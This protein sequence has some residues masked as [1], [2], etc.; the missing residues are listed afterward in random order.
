MNTSNFFPIQ[1]SN[2]F[3][4]VFDVESIGLHGEGFAVSWLVL[5]LH[6][7]VVL[8]EKTFSCDPALATGIAPDREWVAA[9]VPALE[10]NCASPTE[11]RACFWRAWLAWRE[12]SAWLAADAAWPVETNFLSAC[13]RD[14]GVD[15][16][17][18]GPYP[19]IDIDAMITASGLLTK[20]ELTRHAHELPVH[21][22]TA[23]TRFSARRL[24]TMLSKIKK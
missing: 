3:C 21:N 10:I 20:D 13:V 19:L 23:D 24:V 14:I 7:G 4:M 2:R 1:Q 22:P 12:Q 11:V 9:N 6:Q 15:A 17:F 5:D 8:E 18:M 16:H